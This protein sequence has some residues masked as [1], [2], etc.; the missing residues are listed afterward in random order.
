MRDGIDGDIRVNF[1]SRRLAGVCALSVMVGL[2]ACTPGSRQASG[3]TVPS[4]AQMQ[5]L[6]SDTPAPTLTSPPPTAATSPVTPRATQWCSE[7]AA[8]YGHSTPTAAATSTA[9]AIAAALESV[10]QHQ[11][12]AEY[13]RFMADWHR[14]KPPLTVDEMAALHPAVRAV[15]EA[16]IAYYEPDR[17]AG[18]ERPPPSDY[19]VVQNRIDL[20][21]TVEGSYFCSGSDCGDLPPKFVP[22]P[23]WSP[24]LP[25]FAITD[26]R[27]GVLISGKTP[28]FAG[29][30][31]KDA[32]RLL[33]S[34][35][36]PTV[37]GPW[38]EI[39]WPHAGFHG[40]GEPS[41]YWRNPSTSA[42]FRAFLSE[43]LT[44]AYITGRR[45]FAGWDCG[46]KRKDDHSAWKLGRCES[47]WAE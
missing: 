8:K 45:G 31:Q 42:A 18:T 14:D 28:V 36:S 27:P 16:F 41:S 30:D 43:D 1:I 24:N 20:A 15:Y 38:T 13:D 25:Q 39:L 23:V 44:W 40:L 12:P 5:A 21:C 7:A 34:H 47:L 37:D 22:P 19:I 10:L 26:F 35:L 4:V 3:T 29:P 6:P 33:D 46:L 32:L 11:S 9:E 17:H 2:V